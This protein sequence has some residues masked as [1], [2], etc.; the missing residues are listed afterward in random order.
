MI[1]TVACAETHGAELV[2]P[3]Q[4]GCL[5]LERAHRLASLNARIADQ[6][7]RLPALG[8][9]SAAEL[10]ERRV[11]VRAKMRAHEFLSLFGIAAG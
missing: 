9:A 11:A 6:D 8:H 1:G 4:G 10:G 7:M 2:A 3:G 5:I